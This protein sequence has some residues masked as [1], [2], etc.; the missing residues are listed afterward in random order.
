MRQIKTMSHNIKV[1]QKVYGVGKNPMSGRD[2]CGP[3]RKI[4][5]SEPKKAVKKAAKPEKPGKGVYIM[6][7]SFGR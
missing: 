1:K 6:S 4:E 5:R 2:Y 3:D 7:S